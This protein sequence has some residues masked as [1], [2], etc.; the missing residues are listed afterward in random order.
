MDLYPNHGLYE[1]P[2]II[3]IVVKKTLFYLYINITT[4]L[5]VTMRFFS[6]LKFHNHGQNQK[7]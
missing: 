1:D 6:L 4:I 3:W 5:T 2:I 7:K